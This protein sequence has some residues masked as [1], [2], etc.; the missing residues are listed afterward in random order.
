M[1]IQELEKKVKAI[2]EIISDD[3]TVRTFTD[4]LG[5]GPTLYFYRKLLNARRRARDIK[6]FVNDHCNLELCY[7]VLGLWGMNTRRARLKSFEA[8]CQSI[9]KARDNLIVVES[10]FEQGNDQRGQALDSAYEALDVMETN[11]KLIANTKLGHSFF[12]Q[13]LMPADGEN[14]Q[15]FLYGED[16]Q[17]KAKVS[18]S[19]KRY[20]EINDFS[21]S[22]RSILDEARLAELLDEGWNATIPKVIDNAIFYAVEI[23]KYK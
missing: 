17:G 12:P 14:T 16:K 13:W 20:R 15:R 6:D 10:A 18:D 23:R 21:F 9:D 19:K 8:F 5:G 7:C 22:V 4:R 1:P 3:P 2:A 11:C